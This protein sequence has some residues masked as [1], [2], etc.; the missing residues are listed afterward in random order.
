MKRWLLFL[1]RRLLVV[2]SQVLVLIGF[3]SLGFIPRW[4]PINAIEYVAPVVGVALGSVLRPSAR[5][6]IDLGLLLP[7]FAWCSTW[8]IHCKECAGDDCPTC[9]FWVKVIGSCGVVVVCTAM[10]V[11]LL[12]SANQLRPWRRTRKRA[13][14]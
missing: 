8:T 10:V 13:A 4:L 11:L 5:L 6:Q 1:G 14:T 9:I 12:R 2:V 3:L 7:L